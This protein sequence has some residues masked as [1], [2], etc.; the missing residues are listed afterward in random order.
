MTES[1]RQ[2]PALEDLQESER[3]ELENYLAGSQMPINK[4][5][6]LGY[7]PHDYERFQRQRKSRKS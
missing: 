2:F 5:G 6:S 7:Y 4:D 3:E 1:K